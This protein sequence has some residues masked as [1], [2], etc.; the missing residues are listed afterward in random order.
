MTLFLL[1]ALTAMFIVPSGIAPN[2]VGLNY[3]NITVK[4][5]VTITHSK[6][7][8]L[9]VTVYEAL[10][11]SNKNITIAAGMTKKIY[12]NATVRDWNGFND[13]TFVNATLWHVPT[14][15]SSLV[16][17]NNNHYSNLS[18]VLND[19]LVAGAPYTGWYVCSFDVYYYSNNGTWGCNVTIGD[20]YYAN[21]TNYT[22]SNT[23]YTT[24]YPVY[25]LNITDGIDYG[26]VA[27]EDWTNPDIIAN[28]TNLGNMGINV[29]VEGYGTKRGDGLAMNCTLAGNITVDNERYSLFPSTTFGSKINLTNSSLLISNLTMPKQTIPGSYV[30]NSTYWQLYVPP[31]PAGNCSGF[32]LFT[33]IAP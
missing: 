17:N 18:C 22:G 21:S 15:N 25:A 29:T 31:N 30:T 10:N 14:S 12:C 6:P 5:N 7:Q 13:I 11:I 4:T 24:F 28:V 9:N 27:V 16:N 23:G 20:S 32:I 33:A 8:V 3:A 1:L 2:I 26:S 19:S